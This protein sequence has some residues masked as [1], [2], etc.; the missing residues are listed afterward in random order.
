[1]LISIYSLQGV[2]FWFVLHL[3]AAIC[4]WTGSTHAVS[5]RRSDRLD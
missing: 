1:V 3:I 4:T 2:G 5:R